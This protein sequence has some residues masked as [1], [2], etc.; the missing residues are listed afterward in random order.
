M[1]NVSTVALIYASC[2][3]SVSFRVFHVK[4]IY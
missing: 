3:G 2:S 1:E 4:K